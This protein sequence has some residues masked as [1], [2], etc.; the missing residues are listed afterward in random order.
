MYNHV[1]HFSHRLYHENCNSDFLQLASVLK[2]GPQ[3][4]IFPGGT[5]T[6]QVCVLVLKELH[7]SMLW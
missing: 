3:R 2:A 7:I 4:E 5:R 6:L 1:T